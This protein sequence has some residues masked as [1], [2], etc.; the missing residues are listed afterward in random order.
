MTIIKSIEE[1]WIYES[2]DGGKTI[3]R[4][5][6]GETDRELIREDPEKKHRDRWLEWRDILEASKNNPAL[7]D[8]IE[9]AELIWRL[10]KNP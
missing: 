4:R 2:P 7:A 10:I 3:Y 5:K 6:S 9:K 1:I 8:Q